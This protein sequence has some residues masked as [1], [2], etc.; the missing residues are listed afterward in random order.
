MQYLLPC[1]CG[2]KLK[3]DA[4]QAGLRMPCDC[5]KTIEAP[6]L[7]GLR[8]LKPVPSTGPV[9]APENP[10]GPRQGVMFLGVVVALCGLAMT[11]ILWYQRPVFHQPTVDRGGLQES[12]Q[13]MT[14]DQSFKTWNEILQ[15]GLD[16]EP[17]PQLAAWKAQVERIDRWLIVGVVALLAGAVMVISALLSGGQ[18]ARQGV[19]KPPAGKR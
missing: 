13:K 10:W 18:P 2:R 9:V 6:T 14:L 3:V 19:R 15:H 5:G 17:A 12:M 11:A 1:S 8:A 16:P 7:R 4:T